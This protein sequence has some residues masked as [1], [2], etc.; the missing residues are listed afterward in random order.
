MKFKIFLFFI[1]YSFSSISEAQ[2]LKAFLYTANFNCPEN[3]PY[4]ETYICFDPNSVQLIKD[5]NK[6]Y[7]GELDIY[8]EITKDVHLIYNDH[9]SLKSPY[10]KDSI[11]N[12]LLFIDQH[13]I[14]IPNGQYSLS[15]KVKDIHYS[16]E[17]LEHKEQIIMEFE[18]NKLAFSDITL[19]EKYTKTKK[20]R[21][22]CYN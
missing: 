11:F 8:I 21:R 17:V 10:F 19:I 13:R 14:A 1:F 6:K 16:S 7:Y 15:I 12:N 9:Y 18:K 2:N 3:E 20:Q 4:I 5:E 22:R